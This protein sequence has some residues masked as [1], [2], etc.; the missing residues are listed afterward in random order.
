[1]SDL[2]PAGTYWCRV[3]EVRVGETRDRDERWDIRLEIAE[4]EDRGRFVANDALVFS[5]RA[6]PRVRHVLSALDVS[7]CTRIKPRDLIGKTAK[8]E[9]RQ[10]RFQGPDGKPI[11]QMEVP[12]LGYSK[13]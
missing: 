7:R 13:P 5:M 10:V 11:V 6:M 12:Y 8:V 2:I 1:M 9:V 3:A 4:G